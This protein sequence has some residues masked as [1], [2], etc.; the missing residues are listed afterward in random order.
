MSSKIDD[1][2]IDKIFQPFAH[3]WQKLTGLTNFWLARWCLVLFVVFMALVAMNF[4]GIYSSINKGLIIVATFFV[5]NLFTV[6][7]KRDKNSDG[8]SLMNEDRINPIS[9]FIRILFFYLCGI[10]FVIGGV[11]KDFSSFSLIMLYTTVLCF[12]AC[13]PLP[14]GKSKTRKWC[15]KLSELPEG[16]PLK[17]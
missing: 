15:E 4:S 3:W 12:A 5:F 11:V 9:C 6:L 7:K 2:L 16:I 10:F 14:P 13:T 8:C 1:L 17:S